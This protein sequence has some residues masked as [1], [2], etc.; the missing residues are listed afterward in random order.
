MKTKNVIFGIR[1]IIEAIKSGKEFDKVML[2]KGFES[3]PGRELFAL[4]RKLE[5]PF[6]YVPIQK[7][8]RITGKNHQGA[9]ALLSRITYDN[10]EQIIPTVFEDG[11][12]PFV[13]ILDQ[14]TDV[15]N[16]G[17]IIRS[18]EC[19]GVDAVVI[20][21]KGA[22]QINEDS[23]K[24]SAG[25][26]FKI[27]ICR[28]TSLKD[29][30]KFLKNS[31]LSIFSATEKAAED[32]YKADYNTPFALIMGSEERGVSYELIAESDKS[33]KIP[34]YGEIASLNV[35]VAA[36]VIMFEAVKQRN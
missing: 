27:P 28:S 17:A 24:T 13:L 30:I 7:L 14:I 33:V 16:F 12:M 34:I 4:I 5:I 35:S 31:G 26:V 20:P 6:Q 21:S 8:D 36:S 22:A 19:A 2:K 32:Y 11:R 10:I 15:R 29:T 18:A 23:V 9:I 25:A 3:E 1:A